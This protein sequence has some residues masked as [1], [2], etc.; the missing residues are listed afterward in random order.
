MSGTVR[1]A[2][3]ANGAKA[4]E[5]LRSVGREGSKLGSTLKTGLAIGAGVAGAALVSSFKDAVT[6][7]ESYATVQRKTAA[8]IKSTGNAARISVKGVAALAGSIEAATGVDEELIISAQNVLATF[9]QVR[10]GIGKGNKVFDRATQAAVDMSAALGGDLQ[11]A[12][13]QLGKAL[14]D[15]I[16]GITALSRSGVSFTKQQKDQIKALVESGKT[17]QAQKLIL[18]E[19]EKEF[20]GAAAAAGGQGFTG[21]LNRAK[22]AFG[23]LT[24]D[25]AA[26]VLPSLT[27]FADWF[28][29]V[30]VPKLRDFATFVT[31]KAVP[32]I[33]GAFAKLGTL[34]PKIDLRGTLR[35]IIRDVSGWAKPTI[36]AFTAGLKT[37]DYGPLGVALGTALVKAISG[38]QGLASKVFGAVGDWAGSVDWLQ[39]GKKVGGQAL[40]FV[41]GFVNTLLD[42]LFK[43][44]FWSQNWK[45]VLFFAVNFIPFGKGGSVASR[46]AG[47]LGLDKGITGGIIKLLEGTVGKV[48]RAVLDFVKF[49]GKKLFEGF[50]AEFPAVGGLLRGGLL[51]TIRL[52]FMYGAERIPAAVTSFFDVVLRSIGGA[53]ARVLIEAGKTAFA[54]VK[55]ITLPFRAA[56]GLLREPI[57]FI[58]K[59]WAD[60]FLRGVNLALGWGRSIVGGLFRGLGGSIRTLVTPIRQGLQLILENLATWPGKFYAKGV[61][62]VGKLA[63]GIRGAASKFGG[64]LNQAGQQLVQG[65][66]DGWDSTVD[67]IRRRVSDFANW[68]KSTLARIW[69]TH[70][71]SRMTQWFGKMLGLGLVAGIDGSLTKVRASA[72]R[73]GAAGLAGTT[74][75]GAQSLATPQ[76]AVA[77]VASASAAVPLSIGLDAASASAAADPLARALLDAMRVLISVK[78]GGSVVRAL[79]QP[80]KV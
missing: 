51:D 78:Y 43:G 73:L 32:A 23:D 39:I 41:I 38:A 24:R 31:T 30:G 54:I 58:F 18:A 61:A 48:G 11:G 59:L 53:V 22:D 26:R 21:A 25:L 3:L 29:T 52:V 46:I 40:P 16:K 74:K 20:G 55:A 72:Q 35:N 12:T 75:T 9:T 80:G 66:V 60:E 6:A 68:V 4:R 2:I 8:V 5:E 34:A 33:R 47:K 13:V 77:G 56:F 69:D 64:L 63:Q 71:P 37:G 49:V 76:L 42:P 7:A 50:R 67:T 14:N 17:L 65:L 57:T 10:N 44:E 1:I 36:D 28:S 45:E 70:S 27:R 19:V 15:P 79:S 62:A